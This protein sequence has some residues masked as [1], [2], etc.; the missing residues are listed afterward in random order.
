MEAE[1][2]ARDTQKERYCGGMVT[3]SYL[4]VLTPMTPLLVNSTE[5]QSQQL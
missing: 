5:N 3:A 2:L 4:G 1:K